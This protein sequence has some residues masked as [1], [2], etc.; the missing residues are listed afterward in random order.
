M[1]NSKIWVFCSLCVDD[2][3]HRSYFFLASSID[4]AFQYNAS[5]EKMMCLSTQLIFLNV[6]VVVQIHK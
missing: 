5:S 3:I 1:L 6:I 4:L 2:D